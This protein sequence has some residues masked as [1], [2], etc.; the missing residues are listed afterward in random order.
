MRS[1]MTF[2]TGAL[3]CVPAMYATTIVNTS[4]NLTGG[5]SIDAQAAFTFG[6]GTIQI[7]LTNL[8]TDQTDVGQ[9]L[10]GISFTI[11]GTYGANIGLVS[12]FSAT[13][14]SNINVNVAG[15]WSSAA[16]STNHWL[17]TNA[18]NNFDL[19]TIGNPGAQY[20][21]IGGPNSGNNEYTNANG[22]LKPGNPH[23]PFLAVSATWTLSVAGVTAADEASL[24]NVMFS[25]GT[26]ANEGGAQTGHSSTVPEPMSLA[27]MGGGL[28]LIGM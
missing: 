26:A 14:R 21:I 19:T 25:F 20:T 2:V 15:G 27:L 9:D 4:G 18:S 22:S 3:L 13:D 1:I 10:N 11:P 17:F 24:S 6:N 28:L 16:D 8:I 23:E 12:T 5:D 7:T